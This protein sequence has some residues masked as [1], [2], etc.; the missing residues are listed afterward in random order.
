MQAAVRILAARRCH[1]LP[2]SSPDRPA[3][4]AEALRARPLPARNLPMVG[5][6]AAK[7]AAGGV[8]VPSSTA[9]GFTVADAARRLPDHPG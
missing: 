2:L 3:R 1:E 6:L 8:L 9:R 4:L 7:A 5:L